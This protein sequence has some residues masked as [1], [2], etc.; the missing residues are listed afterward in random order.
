MVEAVESHVSCAL[1]EP[2]RIS[3]AVERV[4]QAVGRQRG[5][6]ECRCASLGGDK[7]RPAGET[8]CERVLRIVDM[9]SAAVRRG[10]SLERDD[11]LSEKQRE[12]EGTQKWLEGEE[13]RLA[14]HVN[15]T[16]LYLLLTISINSTYTKS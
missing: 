15:R 4:R 13:R 9:A 5:E 8:R 2:R 10:P 3:S 12:L 11:I 14:H 7:W 6:R 16:L 1:A